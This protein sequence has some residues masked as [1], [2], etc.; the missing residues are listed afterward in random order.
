M[1]ST[2]PAD[3][4]GWALE[5]MGIDPTDV[6]L[7]IGCG[8]GVAV[9]LVC[10]RLADG[11][12]TAI[13]RS[14]AIIDQAAHRNREHVEAGSVAFVPVALEHADFGDERFDKA[15]AINVHLFRK[16]P[17]REAEVLR[18]HLKPNGALY[19]FQHHPSARRT[20]AMTDELRTALE[21]SGFTVDI[22]ATGVGDATKTC[23]V[24]APQP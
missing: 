24:A 14:Q 3:R 10:E 7:E 19:L 1:S 8:Q 15:F 5:T 6:V 12:M 20:H 2:L 18:R 13:D 11:R 9:S 16:E 21:L 22:L 4:F 17:A 23:L